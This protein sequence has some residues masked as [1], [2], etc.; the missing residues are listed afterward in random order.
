MIELNVNSKLF[1]KASKMT[2]NWL[3]DQYKQNKLHI[4]VQ[5]LF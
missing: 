2:Y 5:F 3:G 1:P 4:F